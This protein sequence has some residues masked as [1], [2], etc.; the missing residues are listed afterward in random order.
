MGNFNVLDIEPGWME[1]SDIYKI[2]M[3]SHMED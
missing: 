2:S 3:N 1:T